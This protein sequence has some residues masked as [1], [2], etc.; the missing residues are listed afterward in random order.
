M[1]SSDLLDEAIIALVTGEIRAQF[2]AALEFPPAARQALR[3]FAEGAKVA[4]SDADATTLEVGLGD[5]R[6]YRRTLRRDEF[7]S[8]A[9]PFVARTIEACRRALKDA[10]RPEIDR[11]VLVGGS[12]RIPA[13]RA[14]VAA[15]FAKEP[16]AAMDPDTVVAQIGRAH[17]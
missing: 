17:V 1:C 15:F 14:A 3:A 13:V 11:V 9:A 16:Y 7:E 2:G 8:L 6:T 5:G 4:L 12:T 10:G